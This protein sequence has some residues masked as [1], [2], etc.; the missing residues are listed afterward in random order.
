MSSVI[1]LGWPAF[2]SDRLAAQ[3][4]H[5][6]ITFKGSF[7]GN[8][9]IA[10]AGLNSEKLDRIR[11][12]KTMPK[13]IILSLLCLA[14][15]TEAAAQSTTFLLDHRSAGEFP[16]E[17]SRLKSLLSALNF[18]AA[19][20][21]SY[22][23][24]LNRSERAAQAGHFFLSLHLLQ[25]VAPALAGYEYMQ[26][27]TS[28]KQNGPAA[29][30]QEWRRAGTELT[31]RQRRLAVPQRLPLAAQAVIE[32]SLVQAQPNHQAGLLY[33][34]ETS[35]EN[36]LYYLGLAKG[37]LDFVAFCRK[38]KFNAP[39]A[40]SPLPSPAKALA[41]M[42]KDVLEAYRQFDTPE[43]HGAFIRVN[44]ALK[45]AQ[46]LAR[47]RHTSG[48]WL[49][50]L[51][52]RRALT[53]IPVAAENPGADELRTQNET[54]RVRLSKA[55]GHQSLGWLYRQMAEAALAAGDLK[56]ANAILHHVLP[57][58]FQAQTRNK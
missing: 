53:T 54:A 46:D 32:R 37:H 3:A 28:I 1:L 12:L 44:S 38:L 51:E 15:L 52:A 17:I 39:V 14:V 33:A 27:Q 10:V 29:F 6:Q 58:Y 41:E 34:R 24:I 43:Q 7:A 9:K 21:E 57:R 36:G 19:E 35:V 2:Y 22:G 16:A 26:G 23:S 30:E 11:R 20:R 4:R 40:P 31:A 42:E 45:I 55:A 25:A 50:T 47:E 13:K 49:Q 18:S 8:R 48:V 5:K 56:Q